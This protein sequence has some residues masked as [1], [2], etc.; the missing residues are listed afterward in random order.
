MAG[1]SAGESI[2]SGSHRTMAR[3]ISAT[4]SKAAMGQPVQQLV[5]EAAQVQPSARTSGSD[6]DFAEIRTHLVAPPDYMLS[7]V[8]QNSER[9]HHRAVPHACPVEP[10]PSESRGVAGG[11]RPAAPYQVEVPGP[12]K[13]DFM[14]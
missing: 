6:L 5:D 2:G 3:A 10:A 13:I 1:V 11:R 7:T 9:A 4:S 8:E 12:R 14:V